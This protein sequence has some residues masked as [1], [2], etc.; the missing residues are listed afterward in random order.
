MQAGGAA[1][2]VALAVLCGTASAQ[3]EDSETSA[4]LLNVSG[5]LRLRQEAIDGQIRRGFNADDTLTSVRTRLLGRLGTERV[6]AEAELYD[7]RAFFYDEGTPVGTGEVNTLE[8]VQASL[9]GKFET[10]G[11]MPLSLQAGRFTLNLG[12]R[13]LVASD[14]YRNT[15]NGYTGLRLD[16]GH[17]AGS[18]LTLFHVMPQE[19][20]P[21]DRQGIEAG[22]RKTDRTSSETVLWGGIGSVPAGLPGARIEVTAIG[23]REKDSE[24]RETRDRRLDTVGLRYF[25]EPAP[26]RLD[27]DAELYLQ[28][29]TASESI[30]QAADRLNVEAS[31]LHAETGYQWEGGWRPRLAAEFDLATGDRPGEDYQRF[32]TLY[33]MRR[34]EIAPAGLYNAVG[35]AN[36]AAPGLRLEAAPDVHSDVFIAWRGLWLDSVT[37]AFSTSGQR[38]QTGMAGNSAGHQIDARYRRWLVPEQLRL[39]MNTVVLLHGEFLRDRIPEND[40]HRTVYG[41]IDLTWV[42]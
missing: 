41:G 8:L 10:E 35:R 2:L 21:D 12:S 26:G 40:S 16:A 9:N 28:S 15:T 11:G 13:R 5:S 19:R 14:D 31:F 1:A 38:D 4:N 34:A 32:D 22:R 17:A 25:R 27:F 39:E 20:L 30:S 33:G 36:L 7:S 29:G 18:R 37:D 23:F 24:A 3:A 42:F 6:F